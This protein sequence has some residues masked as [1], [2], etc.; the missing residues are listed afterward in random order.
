MIQNLGTGLSTYTLG[1]NA[2]IF[3]GTGNATLSGGNGGITM[4]ITDNLNLT[5]NPG[6]SG[7]ITASGPIAIS[8]LNVFLGGLGEGEQSLLQTSSGDL[9]VIA[10]NTLALRDNAAV[11]NSGSGNITLVSDQQAP[12]SPEIGSGRFYLDPN[13]TV[14]GAG[15]GLVRIFTAEPNGILAGNLAFGQINE[16]YVTAGLSS[17][18]DP[19]PASPTEQYNT[20]Y[21]SFG[22]GFGSPY[23]IFYKVSSAPTPP[24]PFIPSIAALERKLSNVIYSSAELFFLVR[25]YT[26]YDW[27]SPF[28]VCCKD[29]LETKKSQSS[30]FPCNFFAPGRYPV[31]HQNWT[32]YPIDF[33]KA[34][35]CA[36]LSPNSVH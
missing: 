34:K 16:N 15:G 24:T 4:N 22:R 27:D 36:D 5:S 30:F 6:G 28:L 25:N 12:T 29:A 21:S 14:T 7:V 13:A 9:S 20:Y 10:L 1:G 35:T 19:P 18:F 31:S 8:A 26:V 17:P 23:T 33:S 32:L 11:L 2:V 3:G